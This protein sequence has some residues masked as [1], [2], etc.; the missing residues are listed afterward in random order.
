MTLVEN[1]LIALAVLGAATFCVAYPLVTDFRRW[2]REGVH[3]WGLTFSLL[4]LGMASMSRRAWGEWPGYDAAVAVIYAAIAALL[5]QRV[6]LL[7]LARQE[8]RARIRE[9]LAR[10]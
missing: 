1:V 2:T 10:D 7:Y 4:A 6:L 9:R 3:M 8:L 5:W